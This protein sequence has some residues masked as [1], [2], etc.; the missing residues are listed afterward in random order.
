MNIDST[1][2]LTLACC[3]QKIANM[4]AVPAIQLSHPCHDF[5]DTLQPMPMLANVPGNPPANWKSAGVKDFTT[6][7][8]F[9]D[10]HLK[11]KFA[12]GALVP[13][14]TAP[15]DTCLTTIHWQF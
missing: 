2:S 8:I 13:G 15:Y 3:G 1:H 9:D 7:W 14:R 5:W 6:E 12:K 10:I 4:A 11:L